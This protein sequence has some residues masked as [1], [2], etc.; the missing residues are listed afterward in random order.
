[1]RDAAED[2]RDRMG[3]KWE[4]RDIYFDSYGY[5]IDFYDEAGRP[6]AAVFEPPRPPDRG[7]SAEAV[8]R[9]LREMADEPKRLAPENVGGFSHYE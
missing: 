8:A 7:W 2:A 1:L 3:L 9:R 6:H 5:H 4:A